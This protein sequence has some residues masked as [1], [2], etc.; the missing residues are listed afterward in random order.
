[1]SRWHCGCW[2]IAKAAEGDTDAVIAGAV[3]VGLVA[4]GVIAA[5]VVPKVSDA[6]S[7]SAF[8]Q[9]LTGR[10]RRLGNCLGFCD[11]RA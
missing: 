10:R 4:V 8:G 7:R 3:V 11:C 5:V 6:K 1:M 2:M 9:A